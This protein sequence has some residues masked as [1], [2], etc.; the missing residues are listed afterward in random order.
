MIKKTLWFAITGSFFV[1]GIILGYYLGMWWTSQTVVRESLK[2]QRA[3]VM[4]IAAFPV[5]VAF[6]S[7]YL[8][9]W[10]ARSA[11]HLERISAADKAAAVSGIILGMVIAAMLS[12][13]ALPPALFQNQLVIVWVIRL[14]IMMICCALCLTL[15][16]G[17]KDELVRAF[18]SI[19]A[20]NDHTGLEHGS[21]RGK[22]VDTNVIIDGRLSEIVKSGFLE[23]PIYIP[24]FVLNE[25]QYIA[26]SA[27][28]LRRARGRR[29]LDVLNE[30]REQHKV[31]VNVYDKYDPSIDRL[32]TVDE[33]LVALAQSIS[34]AIITND[35][36]LN[37]VAGIRG[38]AV[39]NVNE[40]ATALKPVVLPGEELAVEIVKEGREEHQGVGYLPDGTMVVVQNGRSHIGETLNVVIS[41]T[42]QTVQGKMIFAE[43]RG[44]AQR[45]PVDEVFGDSDSAR[46]RSRPRY[47]RQR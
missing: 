41:S 22:L 44:A 19:K 26:D 35:F 4:A 36:N 27:D 39:L 31:A 9:M 3:L 20:F 28:E 46:G 40:L 7:T 8:G 37:K 5:L 12:S 15:T 21:S 11:S 30:V 29:G 17:M 42:L 24:S 16:L 25:L 32:T 34:A 14:L 38:V 1:V 33:K 13:F 45:P 43:L 18:P 10:L 47:P 23:G 2:S 6:C